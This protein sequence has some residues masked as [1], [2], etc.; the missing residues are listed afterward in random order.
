M[1]SRLRH[2]L[3]P[4]LASLPLAVACG[5]SGDDSSS[6]DAITNIPETSIR[7]QKD[8]GNCWLFATAA[9]AE[10]LEYAALIQQGQASA[11]DKST[12]PKHLSPAYWDYWDWY[13]KITTGQIKGLKTLQ[14]Y[15][16][17]LDSGGSWGAAV[18]IIQKY[19]LARAADFAPGKNKDADNATAALDAMAHALT[20][21]ALKTK[22]QRQDPSAVRKA[23]D[24]AFGIGG[25]ISDG[26]TQVFGDGSKT[27]D[28]G[29]AQAS[30]FVIDPAH[31]IVRL[32]R[33]D[34][35]YELRPLAQAIG[36]RAGGDD[37]DSRV[38]DW[39]WNVTP[40][41]NGSPAENR[42]YF[43]RVQRALHAGVPLPISWYVASNGDPD[44]TGAYKTT[45]ADVADADDSGGHET[46]LD[47]YEADN[48][49]G[50]GKLAAGTPA[51]EDQ[52]K[53]ALADEAKIVFLRVKNSWGGR[54]GATP[55]PKGYNDL[56]FEY[57]T[58]TVQVCPKGKKPPSKSC[59]QEI[60]LEDITLPAGF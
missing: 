22:A 26:L 54:A 59:S 57:L 32:P 9:W 4:L 16:D 33:A 41:K 40:F 31:H 7:N 42:A 38:G 52:K 29:G 25:A 8:T 14:D 46:L 39:A 35:H 55:A 10:S 56:Y 6:D 13:T 48:V 20:T 49:P 47:D 23:L 45:P 34:G 5:G 21:G 24:D 36:Q 30:G 19:G 12:S 27:F 37:P 44:D 1:L 28:G 3:L 50:V 11:T 43:K 15:K 53:A 2:A 51:T 60:P 17:A 18:E 58:G